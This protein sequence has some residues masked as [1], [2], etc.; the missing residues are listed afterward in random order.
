[1]GPRQS[2]PRHICDCPPKTQMVTN[3]MVKS[4]TNHWLTSQVANVHQCGASV[5]KLLFLHTHIGGQVSV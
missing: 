1:M 4:S 2:D 5:H 3:K